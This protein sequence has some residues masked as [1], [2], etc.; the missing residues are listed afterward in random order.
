MQLGGSNHLEGHRVRP[1]SREVVRAK[2][3]MAERVLLSDLVAFE[4]ARRRGPTAYVVELEHSTE[5]L[6]HDLRRQLDAERAGDS[7]TGQVTLLGLAIHVN[8]RWI[9][10]HAGLSSYTVLINAKEHL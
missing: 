7:V 4:R 3:L 1:R 9:R 10:E 2:V 6:A 8:G 5:H